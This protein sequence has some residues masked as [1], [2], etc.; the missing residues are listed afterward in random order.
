MGKLRAKCFDASDR[1]RKGQYIT[2][3]GFGARLWR[4]LC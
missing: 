1:D 3:S 4:Q 2:E